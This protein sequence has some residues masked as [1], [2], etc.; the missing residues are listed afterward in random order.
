LTGHAHGAGV[1]AFA[2]NGVFD[3]EEDRQIRRDEGDVIAA[4]DAE[5]LQA[6]GAPPTTRRR[7][8]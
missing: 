4:L 2:T 3:H 1:A 7:R 5:R 8:R 6:T